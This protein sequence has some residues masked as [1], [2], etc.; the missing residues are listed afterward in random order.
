[1]AQPI[2]HAFVNIATHCFNK[3]TKIERLDIDIAI[4]LKKI[5]SNLSELWNDM[6]SKPGA[7]LHKHHTRLTIVQLLRLHVQWGPRNYE[8]CKMFR[9]IH[10]IMMSLDKFRFVAQVATLGNF[11]Y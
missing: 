8:K 7:L 5:K 4:K 3:L 1:M 10:I 6:C 2:D 11:F 9:L